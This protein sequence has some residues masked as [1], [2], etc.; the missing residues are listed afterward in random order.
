M[1]RFL[2]IGIV[3]LTIAAMAA[4]AFAS[5]LK[6]SGQM[7]VE[8]Y[9]NDVDSNSDADMHWDQRLRLQTVWTVSDE[10]KVVLRTDIGETSWG[11]NGQYSVRHPASNSGQF[12]IDKAYLE[13]NK[14]MFKLTAGEQ[15]FG[16]PNAI[17]VDNL[18]T[19][20]VLT[21]KTP[22]SIKLNYT[23]YSEGLDGSSLDEDATDD[24]DAYSAVIG[25]S[26]DSFSVSGIYALLD[27][28]AADADKS[29]F[30]VAVDFKAAGFAVKA[31]LDILDGDDGAGNDY[32]GTQLFVDANTDVSETLNVGGFFWY[33]AGD[34]ED[35]I[36]VDVTNWDSFN[37]NWGG[38]VGQTV[39]VGAPLTGWGPNDFIGN[40]GFISAALY[41]TLKVND[42]LNLKFQGQFGFEEE[43]AV[44]DFD[45]MALTASGKYKVATNTYFMADVIYEDVDGTEDGEDFDDNSISFWTQLQVNF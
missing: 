7:R 43:D 34:D 4:P 24:T 38:Y 31:E 35:E 22:V 17:L 11:S 26:N 30:G 14:E 33:V 27:D 5:D 6:M 40:D 25:Y 37:P 21:I 8:G 44:A 20:L 29:A 2:K 42:D 3:L 19:G 1:S 10:V 16:S 41:A 45:Y 13:I 32:T 39:L 23:K 18:G 9:Y 28:K 15:F 12:Q 36:I